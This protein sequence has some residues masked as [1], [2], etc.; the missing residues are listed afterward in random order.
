MA[1]AT[2]DPF[3]MTTK[4]AWPECC[5]G[6]VFHNPGVFGV[7]Q[8][9]GGASEDD[10]ALIE[11]EEAGAVVNGAVRDE[12]HLIGFDVEVMGSEGEGVLQAVGD[13]ERG[14]VG[15]VALLDDEFNNGGRGDRVQAAGGRVVED[16]VRAG[17]D[18]TGDGDAASHA[19]G[20]L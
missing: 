4:E 15:D 14:G 20:E 3:G 18:G 8:F 10:G 19:S 17:D 1:T 9:L 5:L 11:D 12:L 2:A 7:D 16:K 6:Y 13:E